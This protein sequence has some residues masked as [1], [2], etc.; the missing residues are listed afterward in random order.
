MSFFIGWTSRDESMGVVRILAAA[1][2]SY[3]WCQF[4]ILTEA[5]KAPTQ[6]MFELFR[7]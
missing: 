1:G 3:A 2:H 5:E 4:G 6:K 7:P